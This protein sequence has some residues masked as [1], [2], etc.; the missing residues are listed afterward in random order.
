MIYKSKN[1]FAFDSM[2]FLVL[3]VDIHQNFHYIYQD[4][5]VLRLRGLIYVGKT[6][7]IV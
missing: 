4:G 3:S 7:Y 6:Y 2:L 5:Q 1:H